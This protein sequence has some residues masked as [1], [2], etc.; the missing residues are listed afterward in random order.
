MKVDKEFKTWL[1][2]DYKTG[3]FRVTK[4]KP[5]KEK[6]SEIAIDLRLNVKI[7]DPPIIKARGEI[8]LSET[9]AT[10]IL[11]SQIDE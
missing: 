5:E 8:Q 2:L 6:A 10:Q 7:P 9:K 4:K 11:I 1:I 3:N